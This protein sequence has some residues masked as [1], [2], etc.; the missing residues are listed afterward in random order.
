MVVVERRKENAQ[1][2]WTIERVLGFDC[3]TRTKPARIGDQGRVRLRNYSALGEISDPFD[4]RE[5]EG[6]SQIAVSRSSELAFLTCPPFPNRVSALLS[7]A[8]SCCFP[9]LIFF[10]VS[11]VS[12]TRGSSQNYGQ[13]KDIPSIMV[14]LLLETFAPSPPLSFF[15]S[16][17]LEKKTSNLHSQRSP[18]YIYDCT[19]SN[20][21]SNKVVVMKTDVL[22]VRVA[23]K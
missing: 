10:R 13:L 3:R 8:D 17:P 22:V 1:S 16:A 19:K 6:D 2:R 18:R 14:A 15:A 21:D 7:N 12:V 5:R 9:K 23:Y 20:N 4:K 11:V